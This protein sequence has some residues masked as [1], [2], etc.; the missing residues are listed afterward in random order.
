MKE[1]AAKL[2][3]FNVVDIAA[4]VI[5]ALAAVF[6]VYKMASGG[7]EETERPVTMIIHA[8]V[9][10]ASADIYD[11]VQPYLPSVLM[12]S[13]EILD[14]QIVSV[15]RRPYHVAGPDGQW[16]EDPDHVTL[17]FTVE[18]HTTMGEVL[19]SKVGEQEVRIGRKDY[20]LKSEFI[21]FHN[22][23]IVDV[24]WTDDETGL[25]LEPDFSRQPTA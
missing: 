7:G 2:G 23:A 5:I 6:V 10:G 22:V 17:V 8:M 4:V 21:E 12:A 3:K 14:G 18:N 11:S 19:M 24:E 20:T 15:E 16:M 25:P 1:K 9:E 13:G